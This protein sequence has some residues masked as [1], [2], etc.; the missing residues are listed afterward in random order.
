MS[1]S[2]SPKKSSAPESA[3]AMSSRRIT[4]AVALDRPPSS[5]RSAL[6]S[7]GDEVLDHRAQ[8]LQVEQRQAGAVGVV[9]DQAERGLLGVVQAEHLGQ[10]DRAEA[11]DR[12]AQ[13]HADADAADHEELDRVRG[14]LPV[15]PG[16][17][18]PCADLVA[19]LAGSGQTGQVALDVG[20]E[21]RDAGGGQLLGDQL[22]G[23]GLAGAGGA[24]DQAVPVE[25]RRSAPG[26][27]R[28]DARSRRRRRCPARPRRRRSGS[29]RRSGPPRPP[30]RPQQLP[31]PA[32]PCT[33]LGVLPGGA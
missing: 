5:S 28:R 25:H 32:R 12:R 23:L 10:Q 18:G 22:Q 21:D 3:S 2:G 29:R 14:G 27:W 8:V 1:N 31:R 20:E 30:R 15:V 9:E 4:P 24:G 7:V 11:R 13:R 6:P 19:G 33:L 26:P 17:A 16:V